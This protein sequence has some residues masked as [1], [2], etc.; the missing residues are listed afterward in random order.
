MRTSTSVD[1]FDDKTE[2]RKGRM[3]ERKE[4]RELGQKSHE[5]GRRMKSLVESSTMLIW[6]PYGAQKRTDRKSFQFLEVLTFRH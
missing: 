3:N 5:K 6:L 1:V 2:E 4:G